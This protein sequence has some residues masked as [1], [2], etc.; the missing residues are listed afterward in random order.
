LKALWARKDAA[1]NGSA[2]SEATITRRTGGSS[3]RAASAT[4][5]VS[6]GIATRRPLKAS[7]SAAPLASAAA[8]VTA[9]GPVG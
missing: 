1:R 3:P 5:A 8:A 2:V 4:R 6:A 7:S 9:W